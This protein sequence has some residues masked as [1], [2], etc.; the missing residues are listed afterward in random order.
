MTDVFR[1]LI[2]TPL[3]RLVQSHPTITIILVP[4][5]RDVI[6]KH[7][8]FPQDR[9]PRA[10][11]GLPKQCQIVTNPITLSINEVVFG[12][13]SHDILSELRRENVYAPGKSGAGFNDDLL[14]RLSAHL[15]DQRHYFP[16][17][18]AQSRENLPKIAPVPGEVPALGQEERQP[19]G[20]NLD[21]SYLKLAEW[22]KVRPDVL[23]LPS[24]L[25]PFAKVRS[26][27]TP[28]SKNQVKEILKLTQ[29]HRSSTQFFA[30]TQVPSPNAEERG[31]TPPSLWLRVR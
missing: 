10:V 29:T 6:S 15:I 17:F 11:L 14:A 16:V 31:P 23:I 26:P 5:V 8:S 30:S 27:I 19:I 24:T 1:A 3:Q 21:I 13:S 4:S 7:V 20:A 18:P 9:L 2:A 25:T 28:K 22:L 12:I